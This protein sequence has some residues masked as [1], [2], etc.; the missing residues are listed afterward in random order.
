M[1]IKFADTPKRTKSQPFCQHEWCVLHHFDKDDTPSL[2]PVSY[3][4]GTILIEQG[5]PALGCYSICY[6]GARWFALMACAA[7]IKYRARPRPVIAPTRC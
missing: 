4:R 6:N 1:A 3:R 5:Q 2:R 7:N